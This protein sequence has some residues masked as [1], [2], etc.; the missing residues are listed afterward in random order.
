MNRSTQFPKSIAKVANRAP[1]KVKTSP[2]IP[3]NSFSYALRL[4]ASKKQKTNGSL[5]T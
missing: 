1:L 4:Q 2:P 3:E 5:S